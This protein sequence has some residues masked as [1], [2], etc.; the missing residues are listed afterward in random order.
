MKLQINKYPLPN[1][2]WGL[3]SSF[4]GLVYLLCSERN[5]ALKGQTSNTA[6]PAASAES[7]CQPP[8]VGH[9][10]V[11]HQSPG[12]HPQS[13]TGRIHVRGAAYTAGGWPNTPQG[14]TGQRMP[15]FPCTG[16][17]TT[18]EPSQPQGS[19]CPQLA[20]S[21]SP[22]TDKARGLGIPRHSESWPK[23]WGWRWW[24]QMVPQM[25]GL[26]QAWKAWSGTRIPARRVERFGSSEGSIPG[27]LDLGAAGGSGAPRVRTHGGTCRLQ[28]HWGLRALAPC[29]G[30]P[31]ASLLLISCRLKFFCFLPFIS[32]GLLFVSVCS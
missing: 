4:R 28:P 11:Q 23:G 25:P 13:F 2:V 29:M 20:P 7:P 27:S 16:K 1:Q 12:R 21:Q 19:G 6:A 15:D 26:S 30:V 10:S 8:A 3:T 17:S 31:E 24:K 22:G 18:V 32:L 5:F 9:N 14:T